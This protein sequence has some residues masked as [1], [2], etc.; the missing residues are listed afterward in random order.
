MS[1]DIKLLLSV[2]EAA[3]YSGLPPDVIRDEAAK[4]NIDYMTSDKRG[5]IF[6][7][8][9][10]LELWVAENSRVHTVV[11]PTNARLNYRQ[12]VAAKRQ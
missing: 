3:E 1:K 9:L 5:K 2:Q 12:R 7:N 6:V 4:G 11:S 10:S 8:R